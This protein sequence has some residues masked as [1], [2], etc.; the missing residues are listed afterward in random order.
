[1]SSGFGW[2]DESPYTVGLLDLFDWV[3]CDFE[4]ENYKTKI[5]TKNRTNF[6]C[7][8]NS[9][10][11]K[12]EFYVKNEKTTKIGNK[13]KKKKIIKWLTKWKQM[14]NRRHENKSIFRRPKIYKI[15][16]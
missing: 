7:K 12:Y 15:E 5:E 10:T 9:W 16:K 4:H 8:F 3:F 13:K 11:W 14:K 6:N 2:K 1:M